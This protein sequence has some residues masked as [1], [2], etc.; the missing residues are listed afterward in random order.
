MKLYRIKK[1][2]TPEF[3]YG[4]SPFYKKNIT[5]MFSKD[6]AFFKRPE[7]IEQHL[8][9]LASKYPIRCEQR[10]FQNNLTGV[11]FDRR[12]MKKY[13]VVI[14]EV[15]QSGTQTMSAENFLKEFK[16]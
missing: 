6:G 13:K 2:D 8:Y 4:W 14:T 11:G 9:L 15:S 12:K 5:P 7:T 16:L 1:A 3:F 10:T